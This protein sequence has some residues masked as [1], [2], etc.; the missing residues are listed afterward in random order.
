MVG[1]LTMTEGLTRYQELN[2]IFTSGRGR[3]NVY[4][5]DGEAIAA[6]NL[7]VGTEIRDITKRLLNGVSISYVYAFEKPLTDGYD[8]PQTA[9]MATT[10]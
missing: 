5:A 8:R 7:K 9:Q 2:Y 1:P 6:F 3:T 10:C 4:N